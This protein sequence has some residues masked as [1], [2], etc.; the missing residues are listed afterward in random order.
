M[1]TLFLVRWSPAEVAKCIAEALT[2]RGPDQPFAL[3]R[4]KPHALTGKVEEAEPELCFGQA[5]T[6]IR[7]IDPQDTA[8]VPWSN[9]RR[10]DSGRRR[11]VGRGPSIHIR[12]TLEVYRHPVS[13]FVALSQLERSLSEPVTGD[14]PQVPARP[15]VAGPWSSS[16]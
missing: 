2:G 11:R 10:I 12:G 1:A 13:A 15:G 4:I 16:A 7:I 8:C 6:W 9:G 5:L 14:A 3:V